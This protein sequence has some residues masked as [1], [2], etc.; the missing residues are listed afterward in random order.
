[1]KK[2]L[3]IIAILLPLY[4]FAD[5]K[6][7]QN[8]EINVQEKLE[9]KQSGPSPILGTLGMIEVEMDKV[10][11]PWTI[12][13]PAPAEDVEDFDGPCGANN[14][15]MTVSNGY[16]SITFPNNSGILELYE[17]KMDFKIY[18]RTKTHSGYYEIIIRTI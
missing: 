8:N 18:L 9:V 7:I 6:G 3:L 4:V 2:L 16:L 13:V 17:F 1:M 11:F 10:S 12:T 15:I 14:G 5:E